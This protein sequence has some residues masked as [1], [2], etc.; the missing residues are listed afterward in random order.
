[1]RERIFASTVYGLLLIGCNGAAP[2]S[3]RNAANS[4]TPKAAPGRKID[5]VHPTTRDELAKTFTAAFDAGDSES[6]ERLMLWGDATEEQKRKSS[7]GWLLA[8]LT[9]EYRVLETK[10]LPPDHE[11]V[12]DVQGDGPGYS[13]A[14]PL[15]EV[16][17]VKYGDESTKITSSFRIG[18]KDGKYYIAPGY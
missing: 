7:A 2:E 8:N 18:E 16:L 12:S 6:L 13:F 11:E 14:L 4:S 5:F 1:M 17:N 3:D 9:G 10:I 15:T